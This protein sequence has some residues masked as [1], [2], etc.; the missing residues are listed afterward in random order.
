MSYLLGSVYINIGVG[1]GA[2]RAF[3]MVFSGL[4]V[5][6]VIGFQ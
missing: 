6:F 4:F 2:C 3:E 5:G 1:D